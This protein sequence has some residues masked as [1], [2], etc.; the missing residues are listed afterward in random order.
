MPPIAALPDLHRGP[1][2]LQQH[3]RFAKQYLAGSTQGGLL[4]KRQGCQR[5]QQQLIGHTRSFS[6]RFDFIEDR[7]DPQFLV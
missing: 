3:G 6:L 2:Q 5:A 4:H 7:K 1:A